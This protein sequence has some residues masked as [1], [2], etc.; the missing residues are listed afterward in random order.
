MALVAAL[1][2]LLPLSARAHDPDTTG[3]LYRSFDTGAT[4]S[5][6][7]PG[8][9]PSGALA[10]AADPRDANHL[11]LA[12]DSGLWR[13]KNGGRDWE[14]DAAEVL[15]GQVF[16]AMFDA[17]GGRTLVA[18]S[19]SLLNNDGAGWQTVRAPSGALPA[20]A[21]VAGATTGRVYLAGRA[22][23]H[24][25]DDF[26]RSWADVGAAFGAMSVRTV[27]VTPGRPDDLHAVA[28]GAL[29]SSNDGARHWRRR[30]DIAGGIDA[31]ALDAADPA[32]LWA[33]GG[34]QVYRSDDRGDTWRAVGQRLPE[35][36]AQARALVV[37]GSTVLVATDRGLFRSSDG[38]VSWEPP[39]E[40]LPAHLAAGVLARDARN[41]ATLYA[42]FALTSYE[43]LV[44]R[45][46]PDTSSWLPAGL[47][48][49]GT[50]AAVVLCVL[51]AAAVAAL[52]AR[53]RTANANRLHAAVKTAIE[54][55]QE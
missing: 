39:K 50:I 16:G 40:N 47:G 51:G 29:W 22:G 15:R 17:D 14:I 48:G 2:C 1:V 37:T 11:L 44:A 33:V 6:I 42:G 7:N 20:R 32:R 21:L 3:G 13:S 36:A 19:T 25:S 34:A 23:L 43:D 53:A 41:P 52:V 49:A 45:I 5:P 10:L 54:R 30:A 8:I 38:A 12:T 35:A 24:R 28:A 55:V 26:G 27:V 4:W 46:P 31:V 18:T 9:F